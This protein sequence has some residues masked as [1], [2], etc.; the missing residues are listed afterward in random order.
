MLYQRKKGAKMTPKVI[1]WKRV[2]RK[3]HDWNWNTK[4]QI[5][6]IEVSPREKRQIQKLIGEEISAREKLELIE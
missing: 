3:F 4:D 5:L 1:N 2:W 6:L